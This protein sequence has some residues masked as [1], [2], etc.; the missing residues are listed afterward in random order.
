MV[1]V[2]SDHERGSRV[3]TG[4]TQH[5]ETLD[6]GAGDLPAAAGGDTCW[7]PPALEV[8][9]A[10]EGGVVCGGTCCCDG[11]GCCCDG[12][13]TDCLLESSEKELFMVAKNALDLALIRLS[14]LS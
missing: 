1:V 7:W 11:G 14:E 8:D 9:V 2:S 12:S 13:S 4:D 6:T 10:V 3:N 5:R